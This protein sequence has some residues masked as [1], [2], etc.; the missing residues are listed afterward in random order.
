M[1]KGKLDLEDVRTIMDLV[2]GGKSTQ[3]V[4]PTMQVDKDSFSAFTGGLSKGWPFILTVGSIGFWMV[5]SIYGI[6]STLTQHDARI[7]QNAEA[8]KAIDM[9]LDT[10]TVSNNEII[11][12]LDNMQKDLDILK[13]GR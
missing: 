6:N 7:T 9:K 5:Q 2:N 10:F 4:V 12:R 13:T 8:I 1:A 3:T 11:R